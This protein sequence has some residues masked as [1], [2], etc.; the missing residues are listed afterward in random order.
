MPGGRLCA[1]TVTLH[2]WPCYSLLYCCFIRTCNWLILSIFTCGGQKGR[3]QV[4]LGAHV[5]G[6]YDLIL[7][8][9]SIGRGHVQSKG[10]LSNSSCV[11]STAVHLGIL[12]HSASGVKIK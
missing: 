1:N 5:D 7:E 9:L 2:K 3:R 8:K 6:K 11:V 10:S 4:A 12:S